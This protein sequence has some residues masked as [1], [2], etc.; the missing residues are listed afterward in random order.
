MTTRVQCGGTELVDTIA[1]EWRGLCEESNMPP[2]H[3]PEWIAAYLRAWAPE[4]QLRVLTVHEQS[5]LRA[6]LPLMTGSSFCGL[7]VRSLRSACNVHFPRFDL[8]VG[9][10]NAD[11]A[12]ACL[13]DSL[14]HS[15]EW[16]VLQIDNVVEGGAAERLLKL[17][18]RD[19]Y[20]TGQWEAGEAPYIPLQGVA[21]PLSAVSTESMAKRLR[22]DWRRA[23]ERWK[24]ELCR[25]DYADRAWLKEFFALEASGW[26]G[27]E[28]TAVACS[29]ARQVFYEDVAVSA[30]RSGRF[31]MHLLKFDGT[32]VAG[33]F[34]LVQKGY[35]AV[36]KSAY[37]ERFSSFAPGHLMVHA[38]LE[39]LSKTGLA[40]YDM[41]AP[42]AP[43]ASRT[44]KLSHCFVFRKG[45]VGRA[46]YAVKFKFVARFRP[47]ARRPLVRRFRARGDVGE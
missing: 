16:D 41:L 14:K 1:D 10:G 45:P 40:E 29:Q 23:S 36:L 24:I 33:H 32:V 18:A 19:G 46:L 38:C 8:V 21:D 22:R 25:T 6:V 26:K 15:S 27:M 4:A 30:A 47:I 35:Y 3:Y 11:L 28:M 31:R 9:G 13:W 44:R 17:A 20:P 42:N 39:D 5:R 7:P 2:F 37:D 43:W 34:G 12:T